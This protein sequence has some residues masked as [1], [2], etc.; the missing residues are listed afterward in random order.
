MPYIATH[1]NVSEEY[2]P[3]STGL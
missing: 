3:I 1:T 2:L